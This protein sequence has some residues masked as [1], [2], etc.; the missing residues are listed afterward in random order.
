MTDDEILAM[1]LRPGD[2]GYVLPG[3][4]DPILQQRST[5]DDEL[6]SAMNTPFTGPIDMGPA[7]NDDVQTSNEMA[8]RRLAQDVAM[9]REEAEPGIMNMASDFAS[10]VGR[11][12]GRVGS[13]AS[14]L[15]KGA[16]Q[17]IYDVQAA[18]YKAMMDPEGA[19]EEAKEFA[20]KV[21]EGD[22]KAQED[23]LVAASMSFVPGVTEAADVELA[24]RDIKKAAETKD[25]SDIGMAAVSTVFAAVPLVGSGFARSIMRGAPDADEIRR[26]SDAERM[27]RGLPPSLET[28]SQPVFRSVLEETVEGFK[29]KKLGVKGLRGRLRSAG[30]TDAEIDSVRLDSFLETMEQQGKK[31]FPKEEL[32]DYLNENKVQLSDVRL[33]DSLFKRNVREIEDDIRVGERNVT[34]AI[35]D[36]LST[37]NREEQLDLFSEHTF[38]PATGEVKFRPVVSSPLSGD[39]SATFVSKAMDGISPRKEVWEELGNRLSMKTEEAME[40]FDILASSARPAHLASAARLKDVARL[41]E[42]SRSFENPISR[43]V[44]IHAAVLSPNSNR[45]VEAYLNNFEEMVTIAESLAKRHPN[46]NESFERLQNVVLGRLKNTTDDFDRYK[47]FFKQANAL[48]DRADFFSNRRVILGQR[49]RLNEVQRENV[50]RGFYNVSTSKLSVPGTSQ[51]E[52]ILIRGDSPFLR[53]TGLAETHHKSSIPGR[54]DKPNIIAHIRF[55]IRKDKN[56][57]LIMYV[58]EIQSDSMQAAR[59]RKLVPRDEKFDIID[60]KGNVQKTVGSRDEAMDY[61]KKNSKQYPDGS[62][63]LDYKGSNLPGGTHEGKTPTDVPF[64]ETQRWLDLAIHRIMREAKDLGVD[65]VAFPDASVIGPIVTGA[66]P[67][68]VADREFLQTWIDGFESATERANR[69][70]QFDGLESF[71]GKIVP[72]RLNKL[73]KGS[74]TKQKAPY[75]VSETT[76]VSID[77]LQDV[78]YFFIEMTP[79][80]KEKTSK[81]AKLFE[82]LVGAGVGGAAAKSVRDREVQDDEGA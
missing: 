73:Y 13:G 41:K 34:A 2:P 12:A 49:R 1:T 51:Y 64:R 43:D 31:S 29:D 55:N 17:L 44:D 65:G 66:G 40:F 39:G 6:I 42:L 5:S 16:G 24:R 8:A 23:A 48:E 7:V 58:D 79:K 70:K 46:Q 78:E 35:Q 72:T 15:A 36:F 52:E 53:E 69:Q 27:E 54:P 60:I 67:S 57:R 63:E 30:V 75:D 47:R 22:P 74:V 38:D 11:G 21:L 25:P 18:K 71:Y 77:D 3:L 14:A 56:G 82:A 59:K 33:G 37:K 4:R 28:T 62:F 20:A 19:A 45:N 50:Q 81:S 76:G 32:I 9:R 10:R 26:L 80:V 68:Y 61:I